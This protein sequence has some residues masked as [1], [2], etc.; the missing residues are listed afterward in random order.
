[1]ILVKL[2]ASGN[3]GVIWCISDFQKPRVSKSAGLRVRDTSRSLCYPVL[4][5]HSLPSCQAERQTPGLFVLYIEQLR[6]SLCYLVIYTVHADDPVAECRAMY[7]QKGLNTIDVH[8][9]H[10]VYN[11]KTY[12]V[13]LFR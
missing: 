10:K 12:S 8:T 11:S 3:S 5:G 7:G 4:C 13:Y 2:N 1:M 9:L 6:M